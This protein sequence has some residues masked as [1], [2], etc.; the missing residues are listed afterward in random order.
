[1]LAQIDLRA[2]PD[3]VV[4]RA[5]LEVADRADHGA[6]A[7][8]AAEDIVHAPD[9][10]LAVELFQACLL[11][12]VLVLQVAPRHD[13]CGIRIRQREFEV[14]AR[15]EPAAGNGIGFLAALID[16]GIGSPLDGVPFRQDTG[17]LHLVEEHGFLQ[18]FGI[19]ILARSSDCADIAERQSRCGQHTC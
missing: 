7:L 3:V 11:D 15:V 19:I 13:G 10:V 14:V 2:A 9:D 8:V 17:L 4:G 5:A 1:M 18:R 6:A 12:C 16:H